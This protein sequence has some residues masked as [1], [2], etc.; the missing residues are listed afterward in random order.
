MHPF[1]MDVLKY[2]RFTVFQV[3]PNGW[4]YMIGLFGLFMEC[5]MAPPMAVE[6]AWFYSVKSNKND[7]GFHYFAKIPSKELK[8]IVKIRD[9]LGPWKVAYFYTPEV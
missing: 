5:R 8:A 3:T 4:A 1:F 2:F 9:S 6:F 7:K